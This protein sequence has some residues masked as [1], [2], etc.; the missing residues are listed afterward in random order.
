MRYLAVLL[1]LALISAPY[2]AAA[3]EAAK[4]EAAPT[5]VPVF[6]FARTYLETPGGDDFPFSTAVGESFHQMLTRLKRAAKDDKVAAAVFVGNSNSLGT[7]QTEEAR[8]VMEAFKAEG[9]PIYFHCES[10]SMRSYLLTSGA[11]RVSVVPTGDVVLPGLRAESLHVRGLLDLV[12]VVPDFLTCGDYKSA[13]EMFTHKEPSDPARENLNWLLDGIYASYVSLIAEGRNVPPETVRQWIDQG[14]H[15]AEKAKEVGIIDAVEYRPEFIAAIKKEHGEDI[16]FDRKYGKKKQTEIDFSSPFGILKFYADLLGGST[17]PKSTKPAVAIVYVEGPILAGK[18]DPSSFPFGS[19]GMAYSTPIR[20][21]LDKVA[22]DDSVK[23]VVLRV[24]SP[25]GSAVGSEVI[26]QATKRVKAKKPLVVS[27]G[28]V[29][30]SGG[31]YVACGADTI[32]ADPATVTASIGVVTGKLVT[33][34]AWDKVGINFAPFERGKSAA[35]LSSSRKFSAEERATLQGWMDEVYGTFKGHVVAARGDRLKKDIEELAGGRVF[36]GQQ[37]LDL[38]LVD[39]LGGLDDA[40]RTVAKEAGVEDFEIRVVPRPKGF[41]DLLRESLTGEEPDGD[42]LSSTHVNLLPSERLSVTRLALPYLEKLEPSR[43]DSISKALRQL[44]IV[45][46]EQA[47]LA[48]PII[49]IR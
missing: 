38:G 11:S 17:S 24:N 31:Y 45:Q 21:A 41:A 49:N 4:K 46:K 18:S 3:D 33:T 27:M 2:S 16:K 40:I 35:M 44:E 12:G 5:I 13:G 36:T 6:S 29:A 9:K 37:A 22:D 1:V 8:K 10:L 43:L 19:T 28:D 34:D 48:M 15:S 30:G 20:A 14:L 25:G 32:F 42:P 39:R 7:A 26:L 23:G 47:T